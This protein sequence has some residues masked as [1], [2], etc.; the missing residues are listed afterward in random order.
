MRQLKARLDDIAA[1][2]KQETNNVFESI[3][4]DYLTAL[5]IEQFL[6]AKTKEQKQKTLDL[7]K[8]FV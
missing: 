4:N 7:E 1:R 5:K 2:I 8:Q 6:E 3:K